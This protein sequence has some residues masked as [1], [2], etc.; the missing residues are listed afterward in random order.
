MSGDVPC[1]AHAVILT[2][3]DDAELGVV[4]EECGVWGIQAPDV[5]RTGRRRRAGEV[6][7]SRL[8]VEGYPSGV[9]LRGDVVA[10][11]AH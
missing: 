8:G 7:R 5:W 2:R 10:P 3:F 6:L 1:V 4:C 9:A 11:R